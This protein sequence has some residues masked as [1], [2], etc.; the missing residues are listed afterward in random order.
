ML[1]YVKILN[2]GKSIKDFKKG[3]LFCN[4]SN[5]LFDQ[6]TPFLSVMITAGGDKQQIPNKQTDIATYRLNRLRGLGADSVNIHPQTHMKTSCSS[7][8]LNVFSSWPWTL[9]CKNWGSTSNC[10]TKETSLCFVD[11]YWVKTWSPLVI[12]CFCGISYT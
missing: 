10:C 7:K 12:R 11:F 6:K 8:S 3:S 4:F 1:I 9:C 5:T 2:P